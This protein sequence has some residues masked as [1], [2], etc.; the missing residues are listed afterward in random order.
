MDRVP[1]ETLDQANEIKRSEDRQEA[2]FDLYPEMDPEELIERRCFAD[3]P[4]EHIGNRILV[5]CLQLK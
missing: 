2:I 3:M 5:K 4:Q 1:P